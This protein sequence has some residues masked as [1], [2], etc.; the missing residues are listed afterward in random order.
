MI[1]LCIAITCS[2]SMCSAEYFI[3][4]TTEACAAKQR[5]SDVT[6]IATEHLMANEALIS[7]IC[8]SKDHYKKIRKCT[9]LTAHEN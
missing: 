2:V 7:A 5:H 6:E 4:I 1:G 3:G 9:R 8:S